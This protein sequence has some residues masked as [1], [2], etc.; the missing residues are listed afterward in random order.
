MASLALA[1]FLPNGCITPRMFE[2]LVVISEKVSV[3]LLKPNHTIE[4]VNASLIIQGNDWERPAFWQVVNAGAVL[5]RSSWLQLPQ[6]GGAVEGAAQLPITLIISVA[7]LRESAA[8]YVETLLVHA[9]SDL[10]EHT[11]PLPVSLS[12]KRQRAS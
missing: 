11:Q 2:Q 4:Q 12:C 3:S 7:G 8:P 1:P 5:A 10:T 9:R 6:R